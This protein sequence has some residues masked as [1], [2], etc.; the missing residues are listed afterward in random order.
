MHVWSLLAPSGREERGG[1]DA[2]VAQ[3]AT[4]ASPAEV[5]ITFKRICDLIRD[6]DLPEPLGNRP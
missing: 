5:K 1:F 2:D 3:T 6:P 4:A